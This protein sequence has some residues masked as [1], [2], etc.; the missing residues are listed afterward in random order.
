M[1]RSVQPIGCMAYVVG[2]PDG[3]A[4][5]GA[6]PSEAAAADRLPRACAAV[7]SSRSLR[8]IYARLE[9]INSMI[10]A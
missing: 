8:S 4:V 5:E 7:T 6:T 3:E 1:M 9:I 10:V 2:D